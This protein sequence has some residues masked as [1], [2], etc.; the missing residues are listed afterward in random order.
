MQGKEYPEDLI[1]KASEISRDL[2]LDCER[3]ALKKIKKYKLPIDHLTYIRGAAANVHHY[4]YMY[5]RRKL[6]SKRGRPV[7]EEK[8]IL[9]TMPI[10]LRGNFRRMTKKQITAYDNFANKIRSRAR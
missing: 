7:Y 3:R 1:K 10:T 2:E 9:E 5:K 4:N 8:G 6:A